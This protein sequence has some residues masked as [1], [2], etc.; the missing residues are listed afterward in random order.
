MP[1]VREAAQLQRLWLHGVLLAALSLWSVSAALAAAT[2]WV[3]DDHAAAR[4][5]A[6]TDATGAA[7]TV[8]AGLEIRLAPGWHAYWRTP[9]DAG[10]PPSVDWSGSAN[11]KRADL[12][13]PAPARYSLQGFETAA[14]R[15][16]VVLPV[17]LSLARPGQPLDVHAQVSWA[18]CANICVPYSANL[19]LKL[20]AGPAA[21]SAQA[22]LIAAARAR[23]PRPLAAAGIDL[24]SADAVGDGA[25]TALRV[26]LR[27][28]EAAFAA[29]DLFV[30]GLDKGS[31]GRPAV[32]LSQSGQIA[33]LSV[34]IREAKPADVIGKKLTLT[35]V[36]GAR[37]AEFT[38]T[39]R[40]GM[41]AEGDARLLPILAIALLGGLVLNAMPCVLPVLSLKLLSVASHAG[42]ERR[43]VRVGLL[44]TALGVLASF[45]A[46]AAA[47]I[48][49]KASGAAIGW[50]IQF[51][52]PWFIAAMA[53][54]TALFAASL[55]GWL[56][57]LAPRFAYDA[58]AGR[59]AGTPYAD[60][61]ATGAFATLLATPCSAPFVGTAVGFALAEGPAEIIAVFLALGLGMAA[62]YGM[63]AAF[64]R[65][66]R[67]LPRPGR[68]M[69]G[70]RVALGL[71][72]GATAVWLLFVLAALSG[73]RA[74]LAAATALAA[75]LALLAL[76]SRH[77]IP[78]R[79]APATSAA[80]TALVAAAVLWPAL[81]GVGAPDAGAAAGRWRAFAPG[82]I[83]GLVAQGK[84]VFVDVSAA[85]CLTCKVN[86]A[87]VLDRDPVAERLFGPGVVAMRGDW[88]RPDPA[89][90]RYLESFGRYGIPFNAVYGPGR[91][92]GELLPEL[93]T[94]GAVE[95]AL[96]RA[97][98]RG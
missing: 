6:A 34:P 62:P 93:L 87:A 63:V 80:A 36:D 60:A 77:V 54:V 16:H 61:F 70:V 55:W 45:G 65:L 53:A 85:W 1:M 90:T 4:L 81:A 58:A 89:L 3:G 28:P 52:W 94:A 86:E 43:Q 42:S 39:P 56:P 20:P 74:A 9:G 11:L 64:P 46:I 12:A 97:G 98:S 10:I 37:A 27:S 5:I 76:K 50:G 88:T 19:E 59:R 30:E 67:L 40:P 48:A 72:L 84:T 47:L 69:N 73:P 71:A 44:M 8:G 82:E 33:T 95:R 13:W 2:G 23:V 26:R 51:Q 66:V 68:W 75:V 17:A 49:L 96:D 18:A 15:D 29:P 21:P 41:P 57:I 91:P 38:A 83:R 22:G 25:D 31:P 7:K 78:R 92:Q 35:V 79:A 32:A 24:V 14:Y